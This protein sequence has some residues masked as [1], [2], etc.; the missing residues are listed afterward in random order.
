LSQWQHRT[1]SSVNVQTAISRSA[2]L[3][4]VEPD[5]IALV[6]NLRTART[7]NIAVLPSLLAG[8][9]ELIE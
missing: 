7:R 5:E 1:S 4:A 2:K 8:V 3:P 9:G 6:V